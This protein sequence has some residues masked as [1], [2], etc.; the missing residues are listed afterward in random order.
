[1][2]SEEIIPYLVKWT[3][4]NSGFLSLLLFIIPLL[5]SVIFWLLNKISQK[6]EKNIIN[7][8]IT[9]NYLNH[10]KEFEEYINRLK[11]KYEYIK[12]PNTREFHKNL[13]PNAI[14]GDFNYNNDLIDKTKYLI[15]QILN[16][17]HKYNP[18]YKGRYEPII[19]VMSSLEMNLGSEITEISFTPR[20]E[21]F[22]TGLYSCYGII[23]ENYIRKIYDQEERKVIIKDNPDNYDEVAE[24]LYLILS[25]TPL[26][27]LDFLPLNKN[28]LL[29]YDAKEYK[30]KYKVKDQ[31]MQVHYFPFG[32][33]MKV[34]FE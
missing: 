15:Y 18:S 31:K 23:N 2:N 34:R 12:I 3:N 16:T 14:N 8:E 26:L 24:I 17:N 4:D 7:K 11:N 22:V 28:K 29:A 20:D 1:M 10:L 27:N 32:M 9:Q 21:V 5:G 33:V 6:K 30:K 13:F 19:D 25:F